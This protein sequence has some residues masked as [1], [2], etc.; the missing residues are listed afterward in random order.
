MCARTIRLLL[1]SSPGIKFESFRVV[2]STSPG[3]GK[4]LYINNESIFG[5]RQDVQRNISNSII[6]N[7]EVLLLKSVTV[8]VGI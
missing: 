3:S 5:A 1:L 6:A 4:L 8:L 7:V 2:S